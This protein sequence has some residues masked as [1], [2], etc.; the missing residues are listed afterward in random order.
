MDPS[1]QCWPSGFFIG[2]VMSS[3]YFKDKTVAIVGNCKFNEEVGERIDA[4]DIVIR[5]NRFVT[6]GYEKQLGS[7]FTV[8]SF[9]RD[10]AW[11]PVKVDVPWLEH[12]EWARQRLEGCEAVMI[13]GNL[14][15][16]RG[17]NALL[18]GKIKLKPRR[19]TLPGGSKG[20]YNST[21]LLTLDALLAWPMKHLLVVGFNHFESPQSH[22]MYDDPYSSSQ[23]H[24]TRQERRRFNK[25]CK[26]RDYIEVITH[27]PIPKTCPHCGE[28]IE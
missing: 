9:T 4:C 7:K 25:L 22:S 14:R 21:G 6:E 12:Y 10:F 2:V 1:Q 8:W 26:S 15:H 3:G 19:K 20:R 28:E 24:S 13:W 18:K 17:V 27:K 5:F 16:P 11:R 23:A